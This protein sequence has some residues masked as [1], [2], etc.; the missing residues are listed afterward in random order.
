MNW[1]ILSAGC[2]IREAKREDFL[3]GPVVAL[4][5]A[6]WVFPDVDYYASAEHPET[7]G[8]RIAQVSGAESPTPIR[9]LCLEHRPTFWV[10]NRHEAVWLKKFVSEIKVETWTDQPAP[11]TGPRWMTGTPSFA[12]GMA[13]KAGATRIRVLGMDW[14]GVD[15]WMVADP[16][17]Y[18]GRW[19]RERE[20]FEQIQSG[21][22]ERGIEIERFTHA[23]L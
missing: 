10:T 22:A 1:T 12:I 15:P 2:S 8:H 20:V 13:L 16:S 14:E 23:Y 7:A 17:S 18:E 21:A 11:W 9:D 4:N 5:A 19:D 3:D 6:V